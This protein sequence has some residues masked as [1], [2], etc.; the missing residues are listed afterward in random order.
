MATRPRK[1]AR[2]SRGRWTI[3]G[4]L[5]V[6]LTAIAVGTALNLPVRPR[7]IG[8]PLV[9]RK[10]AAPIPA[11]RAVDLGSYGVTITDHTGQIHVLTIHPVAILQ[12]DGPWKSLLPLQG[13]LDAR[14]AN[15]F[16]A[17]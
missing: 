11:Q 2:S 17:F 15:P 12:G 14:I 10:P 13:Q 5:A 3:F 16:M 9:T 8:A 1:R 4:I 7:S 6:L